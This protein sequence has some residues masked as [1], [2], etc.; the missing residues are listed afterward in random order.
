MATWIIAGLI[1]GFT[2]YI[3]GKSVRK[4]W[5]GDSG[6]SGCCSQCTGC[7]PVEKTK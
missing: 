3:I 6:C 7:R 4:I 1:A 2:V 5:K